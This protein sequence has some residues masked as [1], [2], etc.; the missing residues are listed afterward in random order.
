LQRSL[1]Y[2]L[3]ELLNE[4][5]FGPGP[6]YSIQLNE[7]LKPS[8]DKAIR[9]F[10][11]KRSQ[12]LA[13]LYKSEAIAKSRTVEDAADVEEIAASCG[14]F[15]YNLAFFAEEMGTFLE[16]L[17]ELQRLQIIKERSWDWLR[18]WERVGP[19]NREVHSEEGN[20]G[21]KKESDFTTIYSLNYR[22]PSEPKPGQSGLHPTKETT[23]NTQRIPR[24]Q[25][26]TIVPAMESIGH[27]TTRSYQV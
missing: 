14:Y 6:R 9:I 12:A 17:E 22:S 24:S 19:K 1:A 15:S 7:N 20:F 13:T 25:D 8:L 2:T 4:I 26:S 10:N 21:K 5:P 23:Y 18:F 27:I 16:V 11:E 3:K